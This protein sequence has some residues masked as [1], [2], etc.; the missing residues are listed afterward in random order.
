M[1]E[2][3]S[4]TRVILCER[5]V[6]IWIIVDMLLAGFSMVRS[7]YFLLL[8]FSLFMNYKWHVRNSLK[9]IFHKLGKYTLSLRYKQVFVIRS[10]REEIGKFIFVICFQFFL[11]VFHNNWQNMKITYQEKSHDCVRRKVPLSK[12][13]P[14]SPSRILIK[15]WKSVT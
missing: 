14:L 10:R 4:S 2:Q 3:K 13:A 5:C 15:F 11:A 9:W 1:E 8:F 6:F 7:P 12:R